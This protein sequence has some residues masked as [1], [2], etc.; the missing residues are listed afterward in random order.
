MLFRLLC[1]LLTT[2]FIDCCNDTFCVLG[3]QRFRHLF[4]H[5]RVTQSQSS[6]M[7]RYPISMPQSICRTKPRLGKL[8]KFL[9]Q[10]MNLWVLF[11]AFMMQIPCSLC[12]I[13]TCHMVPL[14]YNC[15]TSRSKWW[16]ALLQLRIHRVI[17]SILIQRS[18]F[19][20]QDFFH[21]QSMLFFLVQLFSYCN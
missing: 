13:L 18:F 10:L 14:W 6:H 15:S 20:L 2:W 7:R 11:Q 21:S 5:V 16:K 12:L 9:A 1:L 19:L 3:M 17:S 8:M 4:M